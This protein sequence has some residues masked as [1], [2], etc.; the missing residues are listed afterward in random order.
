MEDTD[1]IVVGGGSAGS[2]MTGR[3]ADAGL[4]VTLIE[5]GGTDRHMRSRIPAL[6]SAIVQN[7]A[8]DWCHQVEPDPSLGGRADIWPAGKM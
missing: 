2:A 6:T 8:Y 4:S 5:A 3:L 7:P 1:I